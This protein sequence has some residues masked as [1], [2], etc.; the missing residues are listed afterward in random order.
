MRKKI[1]A[2]ICI[3]TIVIM[4]TGCTMFGDDQPT[5]PATEVSTE[6]PTELP[7]EP[8]TEAPT[9]SSTEAPTESPTEPEEQEPE[10]TTFAVTVNQTATEAPTEVPTEAPTV[11]QT[12][13]LLKTI[14]GNWYLDHYEQS[15]GQQTTP[16]AVITY[17]FNNDGTFSVNNRGNVSTGTYY[18]DGTTISYKADASGEIGEFTYNATEKQITDVDES[19]QMSAVFTRTKP[20]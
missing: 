15:N 18:F 3:A 16:N 9:E 5:E 7:T 8:P 13:D 4:S 12:V 11:A 19:S 17:T 6:A 14:V 10:N 1:F 2:M 20:E